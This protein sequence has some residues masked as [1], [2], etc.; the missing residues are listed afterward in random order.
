M[1]S[2]TSNKDLDSDL[3]S[4]VEYNDY[5]GYQGIPEDP[6]ESDNSDNEKVENNNTDN[7]EFTEFSEYTDFSNHSNDFHNIDKEFESFDPSFKLPNTNLNP[8]DFFPTDDNDLFFSKA[9]VNNNNNNN[10]SKSTTIEDKKPEYCQYNEK[11]HMVL[12]KD[13]LFPPEHVALIQE[14]MKN[15]K[16][17]VKP[18]W[19]Q[20][21]QDEIWL[22]TIKNRLNK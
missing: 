6:D 19:S 21:I 11:G 12:E 7:I 3:D 20:S 15:I 10:N 22:S 17:D 14:C 4:E 2:S 18:S 9:T 13:K 5:S 8:N 1:P 16:L